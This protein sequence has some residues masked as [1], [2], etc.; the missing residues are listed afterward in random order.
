[1]EETIM[2]LTMINARMTAALSRMI[3]DL[4]FCLSQQPGFDKDAMREALK[5][6][7]VPDLEEASL[8][9]YLITKAGVAASLE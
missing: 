2:E 9:T 6:L 1:M 8:E 5:N 7:P 4:A 3:Q